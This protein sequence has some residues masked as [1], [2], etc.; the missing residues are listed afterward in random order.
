MN[1]LG[2]RA[3]NRTGGTEE[4]LFCDRSGGTKMLYS[5]RLSLRREKIVDPSFAKEGWNPEI[6]HRD[7][8]RPPAMKTRS[9]I[10][11]DGCNARFPSFCDSCRDREGGNH[12]HSKWNQADSR[13]R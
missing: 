5:R 11:G 3:G 13:V 7:F 12:G 1:P 2:I 6:W 9:Q 10:S 4:G 8:H